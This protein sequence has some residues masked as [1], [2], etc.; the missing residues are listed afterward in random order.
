MTHKIILFYVMMAL[1]GS[2]MEQIESVCDTE[3]T[4]GYLCIHNLF[5]LVW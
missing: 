3:Q 5:F 2:G 1:D 4:V